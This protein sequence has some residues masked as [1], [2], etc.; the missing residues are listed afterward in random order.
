MLRLKRRSRDKISIVL[1][2]KAKAPKRYLRR[3]FIFAFLFHLCILLFFQIRVEYVEKEGAQENAP[4]V[5]LDTE[6]NLISILTEEA[7]YMEDYAAKL[8]RELHLSQNIFTCPQEQFPCLEV[9]NPAEQEPISPVILLPWSLSD[10][11]SPSHYPVNAYPIKVVLR[12]QLRRLYFIDDGSELFR[13]ASYNSLFNTPFFAESQPRVHFHVEVSLKTGKITHIICPRELVDKRLQG[14]ALKLLNAFRFGSA[15]K[16]KDP[17]VRGEIIL[18]FFG[19]FDS[20][21]PLLGV[22]QDFSKKENR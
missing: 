4:L 21:E 18:Q 11:L 12:D 15:R 3:G 20:I 1:H 17:L 5:L 16:E 7:P 22:A 9:E 19:T 14:L 2:E 6:E 13:K 8:T 10:A